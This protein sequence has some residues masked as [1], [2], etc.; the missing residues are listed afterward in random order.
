MIPPLP[1]S[2]AGTK[3]PVQ[4]AESDPLDLVVDR[5]SAMRKEADLKRVLSILDEIKVEGGEE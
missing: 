4:I 3:R 5:P 1:P 2:E